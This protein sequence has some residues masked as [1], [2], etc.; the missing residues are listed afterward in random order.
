MQPDAQTASRSSTD[1]RRVGTPAPAQR[2]RITNG[3]ELLPGLDM[4]SAMAR[5][6]KDIIS[7]ILV[8][9]GGEDQCSEARR[10]LVRRFAAAA[11]LAEQMEADLARGLPIDIQQ[12]ALLCSSLVRLAQ[13]V[14]INRVAKL[15]QTPDE[16]IASLPSEPPLVE[17]E[18]APT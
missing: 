9:Q 1:R 8:D 2:S 13:R 4:R 16:Y 3:K 10:Q 12:H 7:A 5:R 17:D 15:V 11:V 18:D 6:F 14:G